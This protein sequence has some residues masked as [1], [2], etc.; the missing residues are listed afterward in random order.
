VER[1]LITGVDFA[2]GANLALELADRA[3]VMGLYAGQ[4]V[5][6]PGIGTAA[7]DGSDLAAI[8]NL[9][10][11]WQPQWI[12]HCGPLSVASWDP[13]DRAVEVNREPQV[14][15]ELAEIAHESG[16]RLTVIS[17]DV[18]FAGPRM[19]HEET[20]AAN[21]TAPRAVLTR[22]MERA[23]EASGALVVRTHA[24]GWSPVA[25]H[26]GFAEQ[27]VQALADGSAPAA[28]GLRYATPILASD[29]ADLLWRAYELR[30]SG[31]YH[32]A[33]AE[34]TSIYRFVSELAVALS[35]E[36]PSVTQSQAG[37]EIAWHEETSLN[38]RRARRALERATPLLSEGLRRF[39]EQ[40][41]NGWRDRWRSD[42]MVC[43]QE[44]AA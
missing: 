24:F 31:L 5:E 40:S 6:C 42:S 17:S 38:S 1:I 23:L 33:G 30:L 36:R 19:F 20:F 15:A 18:V 2:L 28:D 34:R 4:A 44:V 29:L 26:A 8:A 10:G 3:E 13:A 9:C 12:V 21:S 22:N 14:A 25:A 37:S 41:E 11:E 7:W 32:I 27:A 39:A 16:A 43:R 35:F